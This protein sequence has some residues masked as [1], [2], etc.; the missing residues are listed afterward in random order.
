MS[1]EF[2]LKLRDHHQALADA[3]NEELEKHNPTT[4]TAQTNIEYEKILWGRVKN[5]QGEPY[6]RYP[7][8][9]QQPD[10]T[11]VNYM[12]LVEKIKKDKFHQH[13]GMKYWL[14]QDNIT[15]GRKPK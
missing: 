9:Q 1:I 15:I 14:F 10:T 11:N 7:V 3:Y 2:L 13:D 12:A 5:Q 8:Y 4:Q 6:Q